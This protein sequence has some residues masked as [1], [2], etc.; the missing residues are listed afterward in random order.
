M[1]MFVYLES[2]VGNTEKV[3]GYEQYGRLS[4]A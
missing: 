4:F 3:I 2:N 1:E